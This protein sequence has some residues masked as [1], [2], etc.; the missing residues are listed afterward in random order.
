MT[1]VGTARA[2]DPQACSD[3]EAK[4]GARQAPPSK[5]KSIWGLVVTFFPHKY[6]THTKNCSRVNKFNEV[7]QTVTRKRIRIL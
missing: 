7:V 1:L 3:V 6:F 4:A 2:E 5:R